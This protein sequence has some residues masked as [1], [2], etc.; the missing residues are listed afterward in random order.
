[1]NTQQIK[2]VELWLE[3]IVEQLNKETEGQVC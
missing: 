3:K 1:M 2:A